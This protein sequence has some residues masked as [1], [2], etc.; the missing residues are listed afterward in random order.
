M[1]FLPK[2]DSIFIHGKLTD[3]GRRQLS[4]GNLRF[5]KA[6]LL[7][8]EIDYSIEENGQ[9]S[10]ESTNILSPKDDQ[11]LSTLLN[12][13]LTN[14]IPINNSVFVGN[15]WFS[16]STNN[17]GVFSSSTSQPTIS[18]YFLNESI[19][20]ATASTD[21]SNFDGTNVVSLDSSTYTPSA[22]DLAYIQFS[23][24]NGPTPDMS[25]NS[26]FVGIWYRVTGSTTSLTADR[27]FPD[28]SS[29]GS[30]EDSKIWFFP[31]RPISTG[32]GSA[33]TYSTNVWNLNIVRTSSEIGTS[34]S[35]SGYT[36]YDS[37]EFNGQ[38]T[39][40]GLNDHYR[41]VGFVHFTNEFS[42]D[43]YGEEFL[44]GT[45]VMDLPRLM[46]HRKND[47]AGE[48]EEA[49][50]RF[51]DK[52]SGVYYDSI[53]KANYTI[54]RDTPVETGIEVGRV[55]P[56]LKIAVITDPELLTALSYKS[57]RNWTLPP[58]ELYL[59]DIPK[60][61]NTTSDL[62]GLCSTGNTYYVTYLC[63][64]TPQ[65]SSNL[66]FGYQTPM[67]CGYVSK[68]KGQFD[69]DGNKTYLKARFPARSFPYLRDPTGMVA[70]SGTGWTCESVK[71]LIQEVGSSYDS[72]IDNVNEKTW[73]ILPMMNASFYSGDTSGESIDAAS[74]RDF[75]FCVSL[76]DFSSGST[77][78][79]SEVYSGFTTNYDWNGSPLGLTYGNEELL[80][81]NIDV[82]IKRT[83]YSSNFLVQ[84]Q[85]DEFNS[86]NNYTFD[87]N[88]SVFVS[89]IAIF[90]DEDNLVVIG[91]P[92]IPI[93]KNSEIYQALLISVDF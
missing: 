61:P 12:Y 48:S 59:S 64:S 40:F 11:P 9:F 54:L 22:G 70:Y 89:E 30:G 10:L 80:F 63:E 45:F 51:T 67:H 44:P 76:E 88:D 56:K 1:S 52:G 17:L 34:A 7:D 4:L 79:I 47:N 78:N 13:D 38:K 77:Y 86:T 8:R 20:V 74:L 57:N 87:Q 36:I 62:A 53:A 16:S 24:P 18:D 90:D 65:F 72:G 83:T 91:K 37:K 71:L 73:K 82:D 3:Q 42:G 35:T 58:L 93:E 49:G 27:N 43:T 81:G 5:S 2:S 84:M 68:I 14:S 75:E 19:S 31:F 32:L 26:P 41:Q 69:E 28:F 46:W 60:P 33:F 92:T 85:L 15:H 21:S 55:Y 66:S 25:S 29:A 6:V 39:L 23:H 50:Q